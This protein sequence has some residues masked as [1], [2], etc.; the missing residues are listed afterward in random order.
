MLNNTFIIEK[1]KDNQRP[2]RRALERCKTKKQAFQRF[3][4]LTGFENLTFKEFLT[5][6]LI[7]RR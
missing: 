7:R 6:F 4:R 3:K 1:R 2:T 5:D